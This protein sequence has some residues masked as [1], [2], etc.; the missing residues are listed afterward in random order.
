MIHNSNSEIIHLWIPYTTV[1]F[2][3]DRAH[4]SGTQFPLQN[5]FA[6]TVHKTQSL[7]LPT[8]DT[9]LNDQLFAYGHSY[10]ALSLQHNMIFVFMISTPQPFVSIQLLQL[11]M[12]DCRIYITACLFILITMALINK[13]Y[14]SIKKRQYFY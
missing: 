6:V 3:V 12:L 1:S 8:I 14:L 9:L 11:N 2:Y 13:Y 10:T 5:S 7:L 4:V